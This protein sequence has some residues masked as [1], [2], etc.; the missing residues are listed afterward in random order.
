MLGL[1]T[2]TGYSQNVGIGQQNPSH[3]LHITPQSTTDDPLRIDG[4]KP[5]GVADTLI[6]VIN[7]TTGVVKYI[8]PSDLVRVLGV[9]F[10]AGSGINISG[11]TI[12]NNAPDQAV[13]ITGIG[14]TTVSVTY[15]NF[16]V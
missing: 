16:T 15:P 3:L 8:N 5:F 9:D 7:N 6:M 2:Y 13:T 1:L 10:V 4:L 14:G 12:T 11:N